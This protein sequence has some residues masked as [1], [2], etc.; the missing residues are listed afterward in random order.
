METERI[1][2]ATPGSYGTP[3]S[4][5][6]LPDG[7]RVGRVRLRV[8]DLS[9]SAAFYR[10]VLGFEER[11]GD[12]EVRGFGLHGERDALIEL[13]ERRGARSAP[14]YRRLGLYHFAIL[15]P[16]R[17]SLGRALPHLRAH[18]IRLGMSDHFVS[19]ALYLHDPDGL[20]IEIYADRPRERWLR[21]GRELAMATASLDVSDLERAASGAPWTGM[22]PRTRIGHV[23]LHVGDLERAD[24][25]Y[26]EALGFDLVVWSYPGALFFSAG[27]YHHHLGTNTWARDASPPADDEARL[28]WWELVVPGRDD[29]GATAE[30]LTQRGHSVR[31][32]GADAWLV[33]D[34]F[35]A[36]LRLKRDA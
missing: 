31:P 10:D 17:S 23:H 25:F 4:A 35:G 13:V 28:E 1:E 21:R 30:R 32:D 14:S 5:G 29:A 3:P 8:S 33:A 7:T 26:R 19:E 12:G 11:A 16:D 34:P 24:A 15:L 6:R 27:G 22:P 36:S 2:P 20:G 9:R 18:E